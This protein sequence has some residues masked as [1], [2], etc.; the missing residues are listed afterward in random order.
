MPAIGTVNTPYGFAR[1]ITSHYTSNKALAVM[2]IGSGVKNVVGQPIAKVS[3]NI[4]HDQPGASSHD[5]PKDHFYADVNNMPVDLIS[6]L[7]GSGKFEQTELPM[8]QSGRVL[9]PVWRLR[10]AAL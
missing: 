8:I 3:V 9:Y 5:L 7:L 1:V 10:G 6:A 4:N 2:L